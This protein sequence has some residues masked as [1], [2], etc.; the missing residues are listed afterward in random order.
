VGEQAQ[1]ETASGGASEAVA[2]DPRGSRAW[3][4]A[5]RLEAFRGE[6]RANLLRLSGVAL[7]YGVEVAHRHGLALAALPFPIDP[8]GVL[9]ER[10]TWVVLAWALVAAGVLVALRSRV[11][12]R[13]LPY[14]TTGA[15]V[16]LAT[17]VLAL[18]DGPA[19]PLVLVYFPVLALAA[20]RFEPWLVHFATSATMLA[21]LGLTLVTERL[22]PE[23]AVARL[24]SIPLVLSLALVGLALGYV[25]HVARRVAAE[26]ASRVGGGEG[27]G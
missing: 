26:Y 25:V 24:E 16:A 23:L 17:T 19:S 4:V 22:R 1:G 15:D 27:A 11:F 2:R 7:V 18:G 3:Q 21:Y 6:E 13:W 10:L 14:A 20:L 12:P 9:H 8:D 5:S